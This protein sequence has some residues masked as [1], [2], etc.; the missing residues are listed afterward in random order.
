MTLY[1]IAQE[2]AT[3]IDPETGEIRDFEAFEELQMAREE[4]IDN[5]AKWI[6]DLEA[7]AKMV[8]ERADELTERARATKKKAERLREFLQEYL[9]GEKR[10]T[11]DYTIGYRRTEAV[12]ITDEN[13]AVAW[14][15]EHRDDA[16]TYQAPKISKTAVKEI[17]KAGEEVPGAELVERQS[18]SIR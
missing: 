13:R 18:M 4:K 12:E 1:E 15:M 3:L 17:L 16:L 8:K 6:I 2:M 10:K 7:E 11:A 5:T 14:L 9:Q